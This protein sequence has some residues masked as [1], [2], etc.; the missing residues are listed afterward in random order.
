M[1]K[2]IDCSD[3]HCLNV[4]PFTAATVL[5]LN[6]TD[7]SEL[8]PQKALLPRCVTRVPLN[9]TD[10]TL[11][12]FWKA[13]SPTEVT[14]LSMNDTDTRFWQ[15]TKALSP[16]EV[17]LLPANDTDF[18]KAQ[19]GRKGLCSTSV[20]SEGMIRAPFGS[21]HAVIWVLLHAG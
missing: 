20:Q 10:G 17:T 1:A 19:L 15:F 11:W 4:P 14:L 7:T 21:M 2:E 13:F 8:Q 9:D 3:W 6:D 16:T 12:Q 18:S 5:L